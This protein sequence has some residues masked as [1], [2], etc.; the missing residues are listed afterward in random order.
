MNICMQAFCIDEVFVSHF[1]VGVYV[2]NLYA[3]TSECVC[4]CICVFQ[5]LSIVFVY[6]TAFATH[7][8]YSINKYCNVVIYYC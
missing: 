2:V 6:C 5:G 7:V 3:S 4:V 8:L 1:S